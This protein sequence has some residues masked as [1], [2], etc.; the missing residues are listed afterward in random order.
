MTSSDRRPLSGREK[1][2]QLLLSFVA[3]IAALVVLTI[4]GW[5]AGLLVAAVAVLVFA[6]RRMT[7]QK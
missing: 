4:L 6:V 3:V 2:K 7:A 1:G 5:K